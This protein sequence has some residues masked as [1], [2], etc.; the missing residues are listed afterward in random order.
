MSP[1]FMVNCKPDERVIIVGWGHMLGSLTGGHQGKVT[2]GKGFGGC[3]GVFQAS[4]ES[5][6]FGDGR[7]NISKCTEARTAGLVVAEA[8]GVL[9]GCGGVIAPSWLKSGEICYRKSDLLL[10]PRAER[11]GG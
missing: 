3:V 11:P 10:N 8:A 9:F 6:T 1:C 4:V 2:S 5:M 7:E